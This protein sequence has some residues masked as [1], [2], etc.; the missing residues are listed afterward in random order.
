MKY[1]PRTTNGS[2]LITT[3]TRSIVTSLTGKEVINLGAVSSDEVVEMFINELETPDLAADRSTILTLMD[4]LAY[5]PLVIVQA[6]SF[7]NMTQQPVQTYVELL[8]KPEVEVIKLLSKDFGD[9]SRYANA[10]NP[11]ATT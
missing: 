9:P 6:A 4:K 7:I 1:L 2:I 5:L 8:D 11:V 10:K 3:R